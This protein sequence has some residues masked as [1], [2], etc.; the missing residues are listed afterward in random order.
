[1]D[2]FTVLLKVKKVDDTI[3]GIINK[4]VKGFVIPPGKNNNAV[5]C[6]RS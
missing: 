4:I 6:K 1:M 3:A 2:K 5:N